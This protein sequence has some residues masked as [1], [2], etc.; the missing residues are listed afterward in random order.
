MSIADK[1]A[2]VL[3]GGSEAGAAIAEALAHAGARVTV[4]GRSEAPLREVA[5]QHKAIGWVT[6]DVTDRDAVGDAFRQARGLNG[7]VEI[8]VAATGVGE[9]VP[10]E[11]M[12]N[13]QLDASL[14]VNLKSVVH[15]WQAGLADMRRHDWGRLIA[16]AS[17]AGLK[18]SPCVSGD[19]AARFGVVG[20]TQ[21]LAIELDTSGITVNAICPGYSE[22]RI[23]DQSPSDIVEKSGVDLDKARAALLQ[24][25][26]QR[27][28]NRT[29]EIAGAALWLCSEEA[30][31]V[32][33]QVLSPS[34]GE[35]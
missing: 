2:I 10:F 22:T 7:T 26:P 1:H 24:I 4:L 29:D 13:E 3:G 23:L 20:L 34:V 18:G 12:T 8:V 5:K 19:C 35:K 21:A 25:N 16:V 31:A 27:Q 11:E 17:M 33:G 32:N 15:C 9:R 28:F 6:C 30:G 14:A